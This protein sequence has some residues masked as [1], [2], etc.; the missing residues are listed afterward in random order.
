MAVHARAIQNDINS[1]LP[2]DVH[3]EH[4]MVRWTGKLKI[5]QAGEYVL[6]TVTPGISNSAVQL[7][8]NDTLF[9]KDATAAEC[10]SAT[11]GACLE[12]GKEDDDCCARQGNAQCAAG[13][14]GGQT[15]AKCATCC[16]STCCRPEHLSHRKAGA[17]QLQ[18]G[19]HYFEVVWS[20]HSRDQELWVLWQP[21]ARNKTYIP[22]SQ[23]FHDSNQVPSVV[24]STGSPTRECT[25]PFT[26]HGNEYESCTVLTD[27]SFW[28]R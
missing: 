26:Y 11:T 15:N 28:C 17:V 1:T 23:L 25:F 20:R 5:D 18:P 4:I 27:N 21:P 8:I 22:A 12:G 16:Y 9:V 6:H 7:R 13:F 24:A 14:T 10:V 2:S 3:P 19:M